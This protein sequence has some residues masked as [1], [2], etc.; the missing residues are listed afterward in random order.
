MK[1]QLIRHEVP[2]HLRRRLLPVIPSDSCAVCVFTLLLSLC[3]PLQVLILRNHGVVTGGETIEEALFLM[4]NVVSACE[5]QIKLMVVGIENMQ[6]LSEESI[7]Q[8]RSIIKSAGVQVQGKPDD[9]ID[10]EQKTDEAKA[11]KWKI[12]DLEFEARMRMLDNAVSSLFRQTNCA[13][14]IPSAI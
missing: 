13:H 3:F 4:H 10:R 7:K 12:W 1:Q 11:R 6:M 14:A 8:V 5:S 9:S 2:I